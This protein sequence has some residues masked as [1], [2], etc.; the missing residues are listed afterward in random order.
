[1][2]S[3]RILVEGGDE[4]AKVQKLLSF[5]MRGREG[6]RGVEDDGIMVLI[7]PRGPSSVIYKLKA[8][9]K[10]R[11]EVYNTSLKDSIRSQ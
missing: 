6:W 1:M 5:I 4:L 7:P 3:T 2:R 8:T 11:P 9:I 10:Q